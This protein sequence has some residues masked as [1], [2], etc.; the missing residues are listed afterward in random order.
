[1]GESKM[2]IIYTVLMGSYDDLKEPLI[3]TPGW[4]YICY[5]NRKDLKSESWEIIPM[6]LQI[7][8][9]ARKLKIITPFEYDTC[10]WIDASIEINCNLDKFLKDYH[11]GNFTIMRHPLR[12]CIYE[13]ADA[14]IY[15]RKDDP[16]IIRDQINKYK[17]SGYPSNNGMVA[18][19]LIVR[20][21]DKRIKEFCNRWWD[22]VNT[23][24]KR[25]QLSF[26]YVIYY[27]PVRYNLISYDILD[28]K[29]FKI[30]LHN[31]FKM[32]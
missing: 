25:D 30:Y 9:Q 10:I 21:N 6:S 17:M 13:E 26:N 8:K 11:K 12:K 14:C 31:H 29:E 7:T 24:S 22:E 5:T 16:Q 1:M 32:K 23:H 27:F 3:I 4:R 28:D 15:R 19:G 2:K 18:T 20:D